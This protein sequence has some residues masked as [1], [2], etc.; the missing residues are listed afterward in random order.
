MLDS[1]GTKR[2][3]SPQIGVRAQ[4]ELWARP[5]ESTLLTTTLIAGTARWSAWGRVSWGIRLPDLGEAYLGPEA[6]L[7]A[8]RTGYRKWSLGLHATDFGLPPLI[9]APPALSE[10]RFRVSAGWVYEEQIRRPGI[11]GTVTAW[12]PL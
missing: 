1:P 6:A 11:Y 4:A 5:T 2:L 7:Y 10:M 12:L 3:P 8:D 9:A